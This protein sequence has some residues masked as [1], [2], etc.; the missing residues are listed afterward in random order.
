MY[1]K[2][3]NN[4]VIIRTRVDP[5]SVGTREHRRNRQSKFKNILPVANDNETETENS[6]KK[7]KNQ[8]SAGSQTSENW[9]VRARV[10]FKNA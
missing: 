1:E 7:N 4:P 8:P 3:R 5:D 2:K 10:H 6:E 9:R